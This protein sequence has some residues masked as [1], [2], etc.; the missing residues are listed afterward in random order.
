MDIQLPE[1]K[2]RKILANHTR[3]QAN[4]HAGA[5]DGVTSTLLDLTKPKKEKGEE[6]W[7]HFCSSALDNALE[8]W[9][10]RGGPA[11]THA[12]PVGRRPLL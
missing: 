9:L 10:P 7:I 11:G 3:E 6:K 1:K 2:R 5:G 12:P 4:H 8:V